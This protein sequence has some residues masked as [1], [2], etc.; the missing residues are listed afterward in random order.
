MFAMDT[1]LAAAL[2]VIGL[3]PDGPSAV[4]PL[5]GGIS[6]DVFMVRTASR[7]VVVKRA[8]PKLRVAA[9]WCAPAERSHAEV[10]WMRLVGGIDPTLVPQVLGEDRARHIFAMSYLPPETHPVWKGELAAG[11]IDAD[12]AAK[13]GAALARIHRE[14]A[15]RSDIARSFANGAQFHALRIDAYL[16]FTAARH[17]DVAPVLRAM[18]KNLATARSALMHGDISP[19]N[20]LAGPKGPVFLDAETCCIGDPA[21][22]LAFCLGHLLLKAVWHRSLA[23]RYGACFEALSEAYFAGAS[24][25]ARHGLERRATALLSGLLLARIDGKSPVEYLTRAADKAFVRKHAKAFLN[26]LPARLDIVLQRW[27]ESLLRS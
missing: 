10:A 15:G 3:Q 24:W 23:P 20:I 13:V 12:F 14:T 6:C 21:F 26:D 19:K 22:D 16:L 9:D 27:M 1:E 17:D 7:T 8:L 4:E 18:A 2:S 25:E 5:A 11:R